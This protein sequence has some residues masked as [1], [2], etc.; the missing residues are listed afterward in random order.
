MKIVYL[1]TFYPFRGGIAQFNAL[2]Y[3]VLEFKNSIIALTFTRQYPNLLFPG[4]TQMVNENDEADKI[5][6]KRILDSINPLTYFRA[7][8]YVKKINPDLILSKYWMT[9]FAPSLGFVLKKNKKAVRISILDNVIPHEKRFFD[10]P[11]N[12]FFINNNDGFIVMTE[13][14]K[15]DLLFYNP[16][17]T[18]RLVP[19]PIYSHFGEKIDVKTARRQL[20]LNENKKTLLFF[21][22]IRD[23]KGLDLLIE[24]LSKLDDEYQ[25]IIA[26]EVYG[27][28]D[29]YEQLIEKHQ[30]GNRIAMFNQ[31]IPDNEVSV[32]FSACDVCILP[33]KSATQSGITG[34]ATHFLTPIIATD[35][36]GLKETITDKKTGLIIEKPEVQLLYESIIE[37]YSNDYQSTMKKNIEKLKEELTWEK[38]S[39][40]IMNLYEELKAKKSMNH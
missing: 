24:C 14:V 7:A 9:F 2:L 37:F 21:G 32:F 27:S 8:N 12:R 31:Y 3:R 34:I 33:Y 39:I 22:L 18:Y 38:F 13:K 36:G 30:L 1:S 23:Y 29:K 20:K 26:G 11:F 19:H 10:N 40:Q 15:N 5:P 4:K 16:K 6:S 17:A 35:V 28:F 25:L